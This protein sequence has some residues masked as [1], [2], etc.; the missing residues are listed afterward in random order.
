MQ[1][2]HSVCTGRNDGAMI[3]ARGDRISVTRRV[4]LM[5]QRTVGVA[6]SSRDERRRSF[7]WVRRNIW[8]KIF[9]QLSDSFHPHTHSLHLVARVWVLE[10]CLSWGC[11]EK[12]KGYGQEGKVSHEHVVLTTADMSRQSVVEHEPI[13]CYGDCLQIRISNPR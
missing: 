6:S 2:Q 10:V 7:R 11:K 13:L 1:C 8:E 4:G 9:W 12:V 5:L 3:S